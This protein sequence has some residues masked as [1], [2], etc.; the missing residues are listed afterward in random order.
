VIDRN[1]FFTGLVDAFKSKVVDIGGSPLDLYPPLRET[2]SSR[3]FF[4]TE[5]VGQKIP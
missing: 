3:P 5:M 4:M 2:Q 1:G